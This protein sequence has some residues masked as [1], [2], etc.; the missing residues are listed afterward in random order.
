MDLFKCGVSNHKLGLL[1]LSAIRVP[2]MMFC[3]MQT[4]QG[5]THA[6]KIERFEFGRIQCKIM[7]NA[8]MGKI[9][10]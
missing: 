2:L 5:C 1:S 8:E 3:L 10:R 4:P 6:E 9:K 7:I